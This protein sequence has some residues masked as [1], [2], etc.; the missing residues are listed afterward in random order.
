MCLVKLRKLDVRLHMFPANGMDTIAYT[1]EVQARR[2]AT[3]LTLKLIG[4]QQLGVDVLLKAGDYHIT[5]SGPA[6]GDNDV[7][8]LLLATEF[9]GSHKSHEFRSWNL[10][11]VL[12]VR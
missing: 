10:I 11:S 6:R 3:W 9:I 12:L 1:V 4:S 7:L 2:D 8:N 5:G